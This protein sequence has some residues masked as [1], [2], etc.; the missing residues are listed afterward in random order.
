MERLLIVPLMMRKANVVQKIQDSYASNHA[1]I[2]VI[3]EIVDGA[4][5]D[6]IAH[7]TLW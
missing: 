1:H 6:N 5:N 7:G 4:F 2:M 3:F